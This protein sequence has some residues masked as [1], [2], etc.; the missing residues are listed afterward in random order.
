MSRGRPKNFC[1]EDVLNKALPV[2]WENGFASTSLQLLEQ[3]TG[4][5]KSGLYSEFQNKD[6]LFVEC[7]R[8][9]LSTRG[10]AEILNEQPLGWDN[11]EKFLKFAYCAGSEQKGCFTVS[12]VQ[13]FANIPAAACELLEKCFDELSATILRNIQAE[14]TNMDAR[15]I[16]ELVRIY[17]FGFC[18]EL[19]IDTKKAASD[20]KV[21]NFIQILKTL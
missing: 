9:Y 17:F 7:V 21:K 20:R 11:I 12:S 19:T 18:M 4:V 6:D 14:T 2:F 10:V 1:R 5:N 15:Q 13:N 8:H 3:A 16:T